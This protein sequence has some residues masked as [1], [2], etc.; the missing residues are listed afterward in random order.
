MRARHVSTKKILG[1]DFAKLKKSRVN[2]EETLLRRVEFQSRF[3]LWL[4]QSPL[5]DVE[6]AG[7]AR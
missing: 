6:K 1:N 3:D 4:Q 5:S 2:L 7:R